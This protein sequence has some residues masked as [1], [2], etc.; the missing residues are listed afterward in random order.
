MPS[1]TVACGSI[2]VLAKKCILFVM[3]ET[4]GSDHSEALTSIMMMK[5][6]QQAVQYPKPV[7]VFPEQCRF[8]SA[9]ISLNWLRVVQ[10]RS[11][12]RGFHYHLCVPHAAQVFFSRER[13]GP[14]ETFAFS[15]V[16]PQ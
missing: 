6:S 16:K 4:E 14:P 3:P 2:D 13:N 5:N 8:C 11:D 12:T 7:S 9:W 10:T 1:H 15:Q